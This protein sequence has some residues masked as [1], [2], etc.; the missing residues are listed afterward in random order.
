[1]HMGRCG[2]ILVAMKISANAH[3]ADFRGRLRAI[4]LNVE[5]TLDL[6]E[7]SQAG[8]RI[9]LAF[10]IAFDQRV[11]PLKAVRPPG[12]RI[13]VQITLDGNVAFEEH[14]AA[15]VG[16]YVASDCGRFVI[17]VDHQARVP[18]HRYIAAD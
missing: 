4:R 14:G 6:P 12:A 17:S 18:R 16:L 9:R 5:V 2:R 15:V 10:E 7:P 13:D 3:E 1:M 11:G 8:P